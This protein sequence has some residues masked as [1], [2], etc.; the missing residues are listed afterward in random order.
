LLTKYSSN[1]TLDFIN[2]S[3]STNELNGTEI[4]PGMC[5]ALFSP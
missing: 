4:E 3:S 5:P 1:A 2:P